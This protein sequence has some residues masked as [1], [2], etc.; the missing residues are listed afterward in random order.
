MKLGKLSFGA[1]IFLLALD[2]SLRASA[3]VAGVTGEDIAVLRATLCPPPSVDR[4]FRVMSDIPPAARDYRIP[5]DWR[6]SALGKELRVR[7]QRG[8]HWPHVDVC[9]NVRIVDG[10]EVNA[11][12]ARDGRIPPSWEGFY[13][14]FPDAKGLIRF[15]LP[16]FSSE[17]RLAVVYL[18][19]TCDP[20][21]GS[22]LYVELARSETGSEWR[23]THTEA[24]WIS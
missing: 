7:A 24:A 20:L 15:A 16:A 23:I 9:A 6:S 3:G 11:I 17:G 5:S 19:W 8:G 10:K 22:G 21:C 2:P 1:V 18:E 12:F 13:A 4:T 14:R